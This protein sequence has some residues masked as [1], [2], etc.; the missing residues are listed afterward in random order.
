MSMPTV[1]LFHGVGGHSQENWLPW[2]KSAL[3][4]KNYEVIV[5]DFPNPDHPMLSEW[6]DFFHQ[7]DTLID[8]HTVFVGHSLGGAFALRLLERM[9]KPIHACF[10]VASVWGVMGNQF[11]PVMRSF[12]EHPYDWKTIRQN[13]KHF[14]VIH[15]DNDPYITLSQAKEL[16]K[17][18]GIAV[19]LVSGGG[20]LNAAAGY[21]EFP[22]LLERIT[23]A[24]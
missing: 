10:L 24:S 11:D 4:R 14:S 9:S 8:E 20:H 18:L 22:F 17:N 5:P 23:A 7:Y 19:T 2:L 21:R 3:E 15:S 13:V 1:F 12:T 16:A 6:T